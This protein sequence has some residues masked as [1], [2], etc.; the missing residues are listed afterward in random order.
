[1]VKQYN[2]LHKWYF[3]TAYRKTCRSTNNPP[4]QRIFANS[5]RRWGCCLVLFYQT[6]QWE[7]NPCCWRTIWTNLLSCGLLHP[8]ID[9]CLVIL[10]WLKDYNAKSILLNKIKT[11]Y[12]LK[13]FPL[14]FSVLHRSARSRVAFPF[15]NIWL[16]P[17]T[18]FSA[19]MYLKLV[20]S[21]IYLLLKI[22]ALV[23][24]DTYTFK[25]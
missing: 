3:S 19:V 16:L 2:I 25:L 12:S 13:P 24:N 17:L 10:Y 20:L 22:I 11:L 14:R 9:S 5:S 8:A 21:T 6:G 23:V 15:D 18:S 4:C 1:M 7:R